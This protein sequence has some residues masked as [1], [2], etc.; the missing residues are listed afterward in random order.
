MLIKPDNQVYRGSLETW[1]LTFDKDL[2]CKLM[3]A[4]YVG[5]RFNENA[6]TD[7]VGLSFGIL[8]TLGVSIPVAPGNLILRLIQG[9]NGPLFRL[10]L[11]PKAVSAPEDIPAWWKSQKRGADA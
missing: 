2:K 11:T 8:K 4:G 5:D 3:T 9:T 10:G 1:S 6:T 7:G